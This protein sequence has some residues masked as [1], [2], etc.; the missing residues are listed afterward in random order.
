MKNKR[1]YSYWIISI[2][3]ALIVMSIGLYWIFQEYFNDDDVNEEICKESIILR[4]TI[5]DVEVSGLTLMDLKEKYPL[6]C[7][8]QRIQIDYNDTERATNEILTK[9]AECWNLWGK[10][11]YDIFSKKNFDAYSTCCVCAYFEF[12]EDTKQ[13]YSENPINIKDSMDNELESEITYK[14]YLTNKGQ[15]PLILNNLYW[16]EFDVNFKENEAAY[17]ISMTK[18]TSKCNNMYSYQDQNNKDLDFCT[19][20]YDLLNDTIIIGTV[21][22]TFAIFD[23]KPLEIA[24]IIISVGE[25]EVYIND[26]N[27]P[28]LSEPNWLYGNKYIYG[29]MDVDVNSDYSVVERIYNINSQ[30]SY[31]IYKK[32]SCTEGVCDYIR[33]SYYQNGETYFT[34]EYY[35]ECE[36]KTASN[37]DGK[38]IEIYSSDCFI[39]PKKNKYNKIKYSILLPESINPN[40]GKF[41]ITTSSMT[42]RPSESEDAFTQL[43]FYQWDDETMSKLSS[44]VDW[45]KG[46]GSDE[47]FQEALCSQWDCEMA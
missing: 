20:E 44:M 1:G 39:M 6:K 25:N 28:L 9:M 24:R 10:G 29:Q 27:V 34:K 37:K 5:P 23:G 41:F 4:N 47:K 40:G 32:G 43:I 21:N 17:N 14:Q 12:R 30:D 8:S 18:T 46:D 13:Y 45:P 2:I 38:E 19:E 36:T 42:Y 3:L 33:R 26:E 7:K 31:F 35:I 16:N 15:N 22:I 11:E